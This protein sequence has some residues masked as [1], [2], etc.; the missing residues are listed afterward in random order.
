MPFLLKIIL[1]KSDISEL[2]DAGNVSP[3]VAATSAKNL[4]VQSQPFRP[5]GKP[6]FVLT[7]FITPFISFSDSFS[8]FFCS[9]HFAH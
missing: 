2:S 3:D 7:F 5:A 1:E 9:H 8:S 4:L 6:F